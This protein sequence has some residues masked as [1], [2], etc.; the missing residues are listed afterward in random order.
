MAD[1]ILEILKKKLPDIE[2]NVLMKDHT[3]FKIG[4]PARYFLIARKKEGLIKAL[5]AAKKLK[6]PV[7]IFG[8][9]SNLLVSDKGV[10]GLVIKIQNNN[11]YVVKGDIIEANAGMTMQDLVKTSL[12]N[13]LEGLEW[14]GGLPGLSAGL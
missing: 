1:E 12:D 13:S 7:F 5:K 14:A 8:G 3:T 11:G 2:N 4:G 9:G 10:D 6:L